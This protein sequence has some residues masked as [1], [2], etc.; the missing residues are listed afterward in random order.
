MNAIKTYFDTD[1]PRTARALVLDPEAPAPVRTPEREY[2]ADWHCED[3]AP[4]TR[5]PAISS[6][7]DAGWGE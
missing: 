3:P 7:E 4:V 5:L 1:T 2:L 6:P